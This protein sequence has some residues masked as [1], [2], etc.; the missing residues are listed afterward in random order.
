LTVLE[1]SILMLLLT[2]YRQRHL[3]RS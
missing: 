2:A 1:Y 3:V